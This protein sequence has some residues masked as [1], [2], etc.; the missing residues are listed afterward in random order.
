MTNSNTTNILINLI[1]DPYFQNIASDFIYLFIILFIGWLIYLS[2]HRSKLLKFFG[3]KENKK[4]ILYTSNLKITPGLN[5]GAIGVDQIVRNFSENAIPVYEVNLIAIYQRLFNFIIPGINS[6]P[7]LLKQLLN[8]DIEVEVLP[9][10]L[11]VGEVEKE[12]S[13]ISIGSPGY[14]IASS[15]IE[16]DCHSKGVFVDDNQALSLSRDQKFTDIHAGFIQRAINT[17]TGQ[18]TFYVAGMTSRGSTGAALYLASKWKYLAN[19]YPN[20]EPFCIIINVTSAD[21]KKYE[22]INPKHGV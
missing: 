10:P 6:L 7:F 11:T 3:L 18:F 21:C 20:S 17:N 13:I 14:N 5:S 15:Y 16:K 12:I 9:S 22:I 2:T 1:N 8:S 19:K 4:I